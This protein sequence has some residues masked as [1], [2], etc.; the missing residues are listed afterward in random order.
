M[1]KE[2]FRE[3]INANRLFVDDFVVLKK[4]DKIVWRIVEMNYFDGNWHYDLYAEFDFFEMKT[5][6]RRYRRNL[7]NVIQDNLD[8]WAPPDEN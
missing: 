4:I 3:L 6:I 7:E 2:N 5:P 1:K 8:L